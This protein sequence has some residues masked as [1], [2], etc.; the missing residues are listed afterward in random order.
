M[1]RYYIDFGCTS[2]YDAHVYS[3]AEGIDIMV[4]AKPKDKSGLYRVGV[5]V[6]VKKSTEPLQI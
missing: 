6:M 1:Q 2:E 3:P 5:F 4:L